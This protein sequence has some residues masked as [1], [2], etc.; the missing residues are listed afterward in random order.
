MGHEL[1]PLDLQWKSSGFDT[2][3]QANQIE[4]QTIKNQY[5]GFGE[6]GFLIGGGP[7]GLLMRGGS[8]NSLLSPIFGAKGVI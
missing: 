1:Q 5:G 7:T 4:I 2:K 3:N 6:G 8:H